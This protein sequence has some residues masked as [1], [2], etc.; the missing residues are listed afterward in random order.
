MEL[1]TNPNQS[2]MNSLLIK[3]V[4]VSSGSEM[5]CPHPLGSLKA[6]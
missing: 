2:Q 1:Y 5:P 3:Q 4:W 6:L